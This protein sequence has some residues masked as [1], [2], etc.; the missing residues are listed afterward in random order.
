MPARNVTERLQQT[1]CF[2][3]LKREKIG[4]ETPAS[5]SCLQNVDSGSSFSGNTASLQT[6]NPASTGSKCD[7]VAAGAKSKM[8]QYTFIDLFAGAGGFS[9][10]LL[11]AETRGSEFRL[12]AANDVHPN[13]QLTHENR[14]MKQLGLRYTFIKGDIAGRDFM[15]RLS[16]ALQQFSTRDVDVVVGGPPCQGFSLFG[17]RDEDDPRNNL[18]RPYLSV[19]ESLKPK[20]FVME[21]VPGL[22][23]MYGGKTVEMIRE[24]VGQLRPARYALTGPVKV[25]A[26]DF[27][28][29]QI[30]ERILFIGHRS[31][32]SPIKQVSPTHSG[33]PVTVRQA[34]SDL[35]FLRAWESNGH[36]NKHYSPVSDYQGESREGRLMKRLGMEYKQQRLANHDAARHTPEVIARFAMIQPGRGLDSIPESLWTAHLHSSKKWCVRLDADKPSYTVTTLPD[37]LVHYEQHR[38]LTVREMAR[39]QSF[40]DSFE[41]CGPRSTGGGGKG[42]KKRAQ[43]LPQYTQ[44]GNAVPPLLA[45]G[46]GLALLEALE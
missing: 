16:S 26:A 32:V 3:E 29:P 2:G 40:D 12:V 27:G 30:R 13:A 38:I 7:F 31:D 9:E 20:Y 37:D 45:R 24:T 21:N 22:I 39:L 6:C 5:A 10:G 8:R 19:I 11:M 28:V 42:N 4:E 44:V 23:M 41:F 46:I 36:Y 17:K 15:R 34:L 25:N 43:E 1:L 18:F 14:F 33:P 35:A